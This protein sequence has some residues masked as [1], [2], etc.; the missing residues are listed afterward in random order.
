LVILVNLP[1]FKDIHQQTLIGL[2]E[3]HLIDTMKEVQFFR[4]LGIIILK[5][6]CFSLKGRFVNPVEQKLMVPWLDPQDET[7]IKPLEILNM[8]RIT[9]EGI[10]GDND[11]EVGV[12]PPQCLIETAGC[13]A[14]TIIFV[15]T[16]L[17]GDHFGKRGSTSR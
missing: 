8:R 7:K 3:R 13:V 10:F 6:G 9:T 17:A 5:F 16:I 2:V 15:G 11:P 12:L 14:L 4:I 1:I